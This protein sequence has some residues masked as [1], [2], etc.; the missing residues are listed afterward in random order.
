THHVDLRWRTG[1]EDRERSARL[2]LLYDESQTG[3]QSDTRTIG[4]LP[5]LRLKQRLL[6]SLVLD[7]G[8]DG[9]VHSVRTTRS[10]TA[11]KAL[12]LLS[13]ALEDSGVVAGSGAFVQLAWR[14]I[15][16]LAIIPGIREDVIHDSTNT[17]W[18]TDPRLMLRLRLRDAE[19]G[20]VTL[21]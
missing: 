10:S 7:L 13:T 20:G 4:M 15:D 18:S 1:N 12:A 14:P 5:Q 2:V 17:R 21:K 3:S 8:L 19:V 16:A 6:P 9:D 11:Q